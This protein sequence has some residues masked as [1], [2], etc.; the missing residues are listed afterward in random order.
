MKV[1]WKPYAHSPTRAAGQDGYDDYL[2]SS[3][4][5]KKRPTFSPK[6]DVANEIAANS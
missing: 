3:D 4:Y 1:D 5:K 2:D 6:L